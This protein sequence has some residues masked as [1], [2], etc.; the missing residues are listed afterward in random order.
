MR[1]RGAFFQRP[2][3]R[4]LI[5]PLLGFP[6]V[7]E[8]LQSLGWLF[9][10]SGAAAV[11]EMF[12]L[13][14]VTVHRAGTLL[15][16]RDLPLSV[17]PACAGLNVL[18]S[19]LI[20]GSLLICLR[21]RG[22]WR[23]WT[24]VATLAPLAWLANTTRIFSL[25]CAGL[26]ISPDFANGWFHKW[27]GW[28]V[29][30]FM[31]FLCESLFRLFA[32]R[33]GEARMKKSLEPSASGLAVSVYAGWNARGLVAAWMHSPYDR[34][35]WAAFALWLAPIVYLWMAY[36]VVARE[37]MKRCACAAFATG[38]ALSFLG[39]IID[40]SA[41]KYLGLAVA[42]TG[43]V[44]LELTTL[45]WLALAAAWMPG[46]GWAF[47]SYGSIAVNAGRIV[48]AFGAVMLAPSFLRHEPVR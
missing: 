26:W 36:P 23:F 21:I 4:Y 38:L 22:G 44:P 43:F 30:C 25:G 13:L 5:L 47:N 35:G 17:E 12:S 19:T 41:L 39:V 8:N 33:K 31:F 16:L 20:V 11:G 37:A 40:L 9:R 2:A 10:Y 34:C 45:P 18:Q 6:W 46:T 29:L 15:Y 7:T 3:R 27:G 32:G 1:R 24:A 28:L 42:L 48:L 14:G